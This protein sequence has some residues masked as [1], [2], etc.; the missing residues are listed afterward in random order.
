VVPLAVRARHQ[1]NDEET[2]FDFSRPAVFTAIVEAAVRGD[3]L[4][5]AI[6]INLPNIPTEHR[7]SEAEIETEST[8]AW[9]GIFVMLLDAT[10]T[11]LRNLPTTTLDRLPRMEYFALWVEATAPALGWKPGEFLAAYE[12]NRESANDLAMEASPIA[13]AVMAFVDQ[14]PG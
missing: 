13:A 8:A 3:L 7:R 4:D 1:Q 2:L 5:R 10:S 9:P 12:R 11:G 14:Q 6:T